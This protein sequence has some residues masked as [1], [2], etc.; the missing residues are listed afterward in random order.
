M[1]QSGEAHPGLSQASNI[2]VFARIVN[3]FKL[4]L[5]TFC[6]KYHYGCL[7]GPDYTSD[8]F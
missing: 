6:Q 7:K 1:Y 3:D 8:L 5:V 2:N 4:T